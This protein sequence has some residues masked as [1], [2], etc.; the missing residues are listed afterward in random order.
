VA[1]FGEPER[2]ELP[3][4]RLLFEEE[5]KRYLKSDPFHDL[6]IVTTS[7]DRYEIT[8]PWQI[9]IGD[10]VIVVARGKYGIRMVRKSQIVAV[11]V[12]EPAK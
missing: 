9:A 7:G 4:E 10:N 2:K 6:E 1:E 3:H 5:L 11:H 8:D 12:H